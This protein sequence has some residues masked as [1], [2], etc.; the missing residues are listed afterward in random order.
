MSQMPT[1]IKRKCAC[2]QHAS[3]AIDL[4]QETPK[5]PCGIKQAQHSTNLQKI[6]VPKRGYLCR[7]NG[8]LRQRYWRGIHQ[9][10]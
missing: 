9:V 2:L 10:L 5:T 4:S 1:K 3:W 8:G 7:Q 6:T